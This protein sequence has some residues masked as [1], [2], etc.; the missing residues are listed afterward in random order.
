MFC[1]RLVNISP[2][3]DCFLYL[4]FRTQFSA[5]YIRIGK[6]Y[7]GYPTLFILSCVLFKKF[8]LVHDIIWLLNLFWRQSHSLVFLCHLALF[9]NIWIHLLVPIACYVN[10]YIYRIFCS[11]IAFDLSPFIIKLY[12]F[13]TLHTKF[14]LF[15][16]ACFDFHSLHVSIPYNVCTFLFLSNDW[17]AAH[18]T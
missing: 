2:Y 12:I 17:F 6:N 9:L 8:Y 18:I 1:S 14:L 10:I 3:C 7:I 15:S 4:S 16:G 5:P 11:A 13:L